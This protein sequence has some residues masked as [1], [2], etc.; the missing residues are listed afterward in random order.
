VL[1]GPRLQLVHFQKPDHPPFVSHESHPKLDPHTHH[2]NVLNSNK[3]LKKGRVNHP[4][5]LGGLKNNTSTRLF[6]LVHLLP[7]LLPRLL[8]FLCFKLTLLG[9]VSPLF[10]Q[11]TLHSVTIKSGS[12]LSKYLPID[13]FI[14]VHINN[15]KT[16]STFLCKSESCPMQ[17]PEL[18]T[19][20]ICG[21]SVCGTYTTSQR[22][23]FSFFTY[24]QN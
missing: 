1:F 6:F 7:C 3:T 5:A 20:S 13:S 9:L 12:N 15:T 8:V 14:L 2:N 22:T 11:K 18:L 4:F 19:G 16:L 17:K 24:N 10:T 23:L 21:N